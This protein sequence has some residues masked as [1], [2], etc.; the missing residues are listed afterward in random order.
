MKTLF[1]KEI[2][3]HC[4]KWTFAALVVFASCNKRFPNELPDNGNT[5]GAIST[6]ER[7]ILFIV[8]DGAVGTEVNAA[9]PSTLNSLTDFAIYSWDGLNDYT[10]QP[11]T[12]ALSTT[13]LLTGVNS[14]KH[15]V[16]GN[17]FTGNNLANYPTL[18]TRLKTTKPDLRTVAFCS[19][20]EIATNLAA[21]ATVKTS[22]GEDDAAVKEAVKTELSDNNPF[23]VFAQFHDVDKAGSAS[24]Y[25]VASSGYKAAILKVDAYIGEILTAMRARKSFKEENWMVVITSNKGSNV[26]YNPVGTPWSAFND[27]RHNT[28]FFC[29]NPRFKSQHLSK[30]TVIPYIGSSAFYSGTQSLNRRAKVLDGGTTYDMGATGGYTIQCKV[31]FPLG[32]FNYPAF[33]AKRASLTA[34]V[35]GWL[36]F[37]EGDYWQVNLSQAAMANKQLRGHAIADGQW[38]TLT[39]V[40]RQVGAARNLYTYTDGVLYTTGITDATRNIATYGNLNSPQPL[41]VGNLPPDNNTGLQDYLVT[42]IRIYN[43]DLSDAYIAGNFCKT[44]VEATDPYKTNLVGFWPS[45]SVNPDKTIP[46]A[47]GNNHPLVLEGYNPA[48]FSDI[49]P[50]V[51]PAVS[52]AVYKTV[53]NGVDVAVQVY[54]WLGIPVPASWALDGRNWIP[55][56]LDVGG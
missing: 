47:S 13:T 27:L 52:D 37:R 2:S 38:H 45:T 21:D 22:F 23:L 7:K 33:L 36:F 46:D 54:Q 44:D 29:Y 31:K 10:N 32:N 9:V 43:T 4:W 12:N 16:T 15:K 3:F 49:T 6:V 51:C 40:V 19:S 11:I 1:F 30:P 48:T 55:A 41:T 5:T 25:T 17:V 26:P 53:P 24:S 35:V 42:D 39:A 18:F 20:P 56:Y 34:G 8:V 50:G 14:G 28:F